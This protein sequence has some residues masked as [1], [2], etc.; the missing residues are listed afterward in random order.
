[1]EGGRDGAL[2]IAGGTAF[3]LF[4]CE[5]VRATE[6]RPLGVPA[7]RFAIDELGRVPADEAGRDGDKED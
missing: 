1:M 7:R 6:A 3:S 2:D 4:D 5:F